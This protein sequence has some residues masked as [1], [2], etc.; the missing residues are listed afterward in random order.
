MKRILYKAAFVI[1]FP[2]WLLAQNGSWASSP[3]DPLL[4]YY[5]F[6]HGERAD[7]AELRSLNLQE[8]SQDELQ[9]YI[10]KMDEL[11]L[12]EYAISKHFYMAHTY[13]YLKVSWN[14]RGLSSC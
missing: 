11:T 6:F 5:H 4:A 1:M 2:F 14:T 8:L 10:Q 3:Q 12:I 7:F 13:R 9:E